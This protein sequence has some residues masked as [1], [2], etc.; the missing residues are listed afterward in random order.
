VDEIWLADR[1]WPSEG[2]NINKQETG[3]SIEPQRPPS[4]KIDMTSYLCRGWSDLD[5]I[6]YSDAE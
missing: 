5:E 1:F 2:S 4:L 6:W 3:S